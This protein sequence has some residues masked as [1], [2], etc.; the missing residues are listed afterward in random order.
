M[1]DNARLHNR[2]QTVAQEFVTQNINLGPEEAL[3][4]HVVEFAGD[5]LQS[6]LS[7]LQPYTLVQTTTEIGTS[8]WKLVLTGSV[9]G[10]TYTRRF[11][12][13]GIAQAGQFEYDPGI[14]IRVL[15]FLSNP[16]IATVLFLVGLY[17]IIIGF[18]TPGYGLEIAGAVMFFLALVG[19]GII[20]INVAAALLFIL[21]IILTL[22]EIKT[23]IGVFALA[24]IGMIILGSFLAF[25]LPGWELLSVKA[26]E[27][28]RQTLISVALVMSGI[29]GFVVYKVAQARRMKVKAGPEQLMG[30]A[31]K[32]ISPLEPRGEVSV[33]GQIWRAETIGDH[34]KQG[35]QVEVVG[36]EGLILRVKPK[37]PQV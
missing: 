8:V 30:Q 14:S 25:P 29:F 16:V 35:E 33:E 23:H 15:V 6:L 3:R 22:I 18:K 1:R 12:F 9:G 36:R 27:S 20:G 19:F 31:G 28:A 34:V 17:A 26:V 32:A 2:N 4:L 21:G 24:G 11:D 13:S 5:T 10:L 37:Q 7:Q